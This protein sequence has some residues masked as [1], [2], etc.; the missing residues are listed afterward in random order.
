MLEKIRSILVGLSLIVIASLLGLYL[1]VQM[2]KGEA[3][4]GSKDSSLPPTNFEELTLNEPG[5]GYLLC[6]KSLCAKATTDGPAP[7]F[8]VSALELRAFIA[9][10]RDSLPTVTT[11]HI[12]MRTSQFDFL[13]RLPGQHLP[14][15]VSLR[16]IPGTQYN[17]Q[18]AIFSNVP[19]G[20]A[21][22]ETDQ[23]RVERWVRQITR[24]LAKPAS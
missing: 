7:V 11:H 13:E 20:N 19:L 23:E 1:Y 10:Y 14:A 24:Y 2:G 9:N 22:D 17:S 5:S 3:I 4:F 15:L 16:I 6:P 12:N 8:S 21:G 18:L